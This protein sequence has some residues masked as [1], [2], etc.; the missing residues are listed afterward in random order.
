MCR[1]CIEYQNTDT[2]RYIDGTEIERRE[3]GADTGRNGT[4]EGGRACMCGEIKTDREIERQ[5]NR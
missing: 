1:G 3:R 4:M 5:T 2:H